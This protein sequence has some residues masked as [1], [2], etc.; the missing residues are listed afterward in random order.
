MFVSQKRMQ[1]LLELQVAALSKAHSEEVA[2]LRGRLERLE[3]AILEMKRSGFD[4]MVQHTMEE[5]EDI[6]LPDVVLSAIHSVTAGS[7]RAL[8]RELADFARGQLGLDEDPEDVADMIH[9]GGRR[10]TVTN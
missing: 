2:F 1:E 4:Y 10:V 8:E 9:K 3:D 6:A 5:M 7:D